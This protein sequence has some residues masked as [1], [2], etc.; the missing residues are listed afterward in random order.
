MKVY[1]SKPKEFRHLAILIMGFGI[2]YIFNTVDFASSNYLPVLLWGLFLILGI[3]YFFYSYGKKTRKIVVSDEK[4]EYFNPKL[5]FSVDLKDIILIKSFQEMKKST[6][7]LII[8][9]EEE[10]LSISSNFFDRILLVQCFRDLQEHF[11]DDKKIAI[12]DDRDWSNE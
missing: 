6:E 9:T 12:E 10:T 7:N 11:K 4:L 1:E 3:G 8:M 5:H 2:V